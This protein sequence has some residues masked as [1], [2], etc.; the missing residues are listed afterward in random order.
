VAT[1]SNSPGT[2]GLA[3][4]LST[5]TTTIAISSD[6]VSASATM[7]VGAAALASIVIAPATP[8]IPL[9]TTRQF[10]AAGSYTDGRI[11]DM[12]STATWSS[13]SANI[14]MISNDAGTAGLATGSALGTTNIKA[15][16]GPVSN[17]TLLTVGNAALVSILITPISPSIALGFPQQ[18]AATGSYSDG[19]TQNLTQSV[20][21][22][23]SLSTIAAID[24]AGLASSTSIGST[25]I[26][27][28]LG[29]LNASSLLTVSPPVP[30]SLLV[31][32][33]NPTVFLGGQ[34]QFAATLVYS[35]GSSQDVTSGVSWTSSNPAVATVGNGG[36]A[37]ATASGSATVE[38]VWGAN[39]LVSSTTIA[40]PVPTMSITPAAASAMSG[41]AQ[42]FIATVT[43]SS[44]QNVSWT[45]DG[46]ANGNST[47]GTISATGLYTAPPMIGSH[48]IAAIAQSSS[49]IQAT[50]TVT[51][52][53]SG[54]IPNTFFGMHLNNIAD[55]IPGSMQ[56]SARIWD[57]AGAQWPSVNTASGIF[58][59]N[60]LDTLLADYKVAGIDDVLYTLWRVPQ[61]A[62]SNPTDTNCDY[63]AGGFTGGCDPPT[64]LNADGTGSNLIWRT[65]VQNIA[66][67]VDDP[68][69][70][71]NHARVKYWEPCNECYRSPTLNPLYTAANYAYRG[72]YAQLVRMMQ[73]AR[74]IIVGNPD[75]AITALN[76]TCGQAGYPVIG[77]DPTAQMVMPDT[78]PGQAGTKQNPYAQVM[79][80]FL[81]CTCAN[82]S[83]SASSTGC[84]TGASG[85]RAVD[86]IA[87]HLYA[88]TYTPE[89]LPTQAALVRSYLSMS[90]LEKPFW[91]IEGGW[92][93]NTALQVQSDPD[94]E[95]AF[96]ARYTLMVWASGTTR[97]YWYGWDYTVFGTLWGTTAT[98]GCRTQYANG[99]ICMPGIAY[100]QI[101]DW[102]LGAVLTAC[103]VEGTTWHCRLTES[104][105][106]PADIVWDTSQSCSSGSCGT[107]QH[108]VAPEYIKYRDLTGTTLA[109][110]GSMVP[111]GIKPILLETQ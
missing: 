85:S 104:N 26:T 29:S 101:H 17:S 3:L 89:Q 99:Y 22:T 83:C 18:F 78:A 63:L 48:T 55:P 66:Q 36:L 41:G 90:D 42:Q 79:Q 103:S 43:G 98:N 10:T 61:W 20:N 49:S 58:D 91:N 87:T 95:A 2:Q 15:V 109:V 59:W 5:G 107:I 21:W 14:A 82:N 72:T 51:V 80:N 6:S 67:R 106:A 9:G 77:I 68:I 4:T 31:T 7:M 47:I 57:S 24:A 86:I 84:P 102:L 25:S 32:P 40:V 92:G 56:G 111:V 70:L 46:V 35:N 37:S 97:A 65:W 73:D 45:V 19:S 81:Y 16:F 53:S 74:C 34:Q 13:S 12:T 52:G 62:S 33:I 30:V 60:K 28:T 50:A 110:Y 75:E 27:A 38:A 100:Q 93:R 88:N 69:Y 1:I 71:R 108:S 105:G 96:V 64:D 39:L 76:T 23:S 94:L 44:N 54:P 11:Q 8:I